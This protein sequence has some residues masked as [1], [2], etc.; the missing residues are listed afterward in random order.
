MIVNKENSALPVNP[1]IWPKNQ[2][3]G[4]MVSVGRTKTLQQNNA[5]VRLVIAVDILEE[6]QIG[7]GCYDNTT[8]PEFEAQRIVDVSKIFRRSATPS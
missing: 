1:T 6:Q 4:G 3:V 8:S 5:F 2:I 7:P